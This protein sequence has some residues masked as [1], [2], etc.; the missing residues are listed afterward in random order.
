MKFYSQIVKE[1]CCSEKP[2]A[3]LNKL[4]NF[5]YYARLVKIRQVCYSGRLFYA[6]MTILHIGQLGIG[7]W[8]HTAPSLRERRVEML[9]QEASRRGQTVTL[10]ATPP[11]ISPRLSHA[12]GVTIVRHASL[13][14]QQPGGWVYI[15]LSF[16]TLWRQQPD[17]AH[18]HGWRAGALAWLAALLTPESKIVWTI[19]TLSPQKN[20]RE[21]LILRQ[22]AYVCDMVTVPSRTL[23]Y[24]LHTLYNV[25]AHYIPDGYAPAT[26]RPLSLSHMGLRSGQY[27]VV[28][29]G[30]VKTLQ[31]IHKLYGKIISRK[32]LVLVAADGETVPATAKEPRAVWLENVFSR[33][34][35]AVL[36]GAAAVIIADETVTTETLL[37]AM[38][39]GRAIFAPAVARYEEVLGV[40]GHYFRLTRLQELTALWRAA[41]KKNFTGRLLGAQAQ[42]R[43]S[44][45]FTWE[46]VT[47]EYIAAYAASAHAQAIDSLAAAPVQSKELSAVGK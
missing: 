46:R 14:P 41:T 33:R 6:P 36:R 39:H 28:L 9:A 24:L 43:A 25:R 45:H 21:R 2:K 31:R 10:T 32:K 27:Y 13:N 37:S 34:L 1:L 44:R 35:D 38:A 19:D 29:G 18:L 11:Y 23:Q 20:T 7:L 40:D 22:A 42:A 26:L 8:S 15:A 4:R 5:S 3:P 16:W 12:H 30:S 17:V 47:K